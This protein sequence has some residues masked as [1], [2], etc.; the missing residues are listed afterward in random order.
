M[1]SPENSA[2]GNRPGSATRPMTAPALRALSLGAGVQSSA[3]LLLA[4]D[5]VIPRFDVAIF[6]DTGWEPTEVYSH[7]D[8]LKKVAADA[9]IPVMCVSSGDIRRDALDPDHRFVSMPLF[10]LGPN[11]ERGMARRQCTAEYKIRPIKAAVRSLLGYPHPRRVPK[12]V[13]AEQTIGISVDEFHRAKDADV[14]YLRNVFPLLTLGWTRTDCRAY[15]TSRGLETTPRSA[16]VGCPYH[17]DSEWLH[18]RDTDPDAWAEAVAF[19][20]AIRHGHPRARANGTELRGT[21]YLH[22]SRRPLAEADLSKNA[23]NPEAEG[24]SPW[25]C[26]SGVSV[27]IGRRPE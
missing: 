21:Y 25:S 5:R 27:E 8:R 16:C 4:V 12:G 14:A 3:L 20:E 1:R 15:L 6:A 11:G 24:C 26:H 22:H 19:D 18:I 7:L 9:D 17:R 23:A 10:V 13:Y 2:V